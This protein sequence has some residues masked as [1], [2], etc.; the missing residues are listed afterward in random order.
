MREPVDEPEEPRLLSLCQVASLCIL[1]SIGWL[2]IAWLV[3][4]I[5]SHL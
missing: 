5:K 2:A 1:V 4:F 3:F